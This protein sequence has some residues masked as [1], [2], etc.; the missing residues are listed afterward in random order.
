MI[1]P[2]TTTAAPSRRTSRIVALDIA[3]GI[4]ILGTLGTNIWIFSHPAG[5]LGYLSEPT[6]PVEGWQP[7]AQRFL[8]AL[9]NGKFLGLL[10]LMFGIGLAIQQQSAVRRGRRWPGSYPW[11]TALLFL[12]GVLHYF[13]VV[14]FDVLMGYAVTGLIVAWIIA[15]TPAA[16]RRWIMITAGVHVVI[17]LALTAL[18]IGSG[19]AQRYNGPNPYADGSWFDLVRLRW[20][21]L[22]LFRLEPV[23]ILLMGIALFTLGARLLSAGLFEGRG[24]PLRQRLIMVG[25]GALALDLILAMTAPDTVLISR[26]V[27]APIVALGLLSAIAAFWLDRSPG[28]IGRRL[29]EV[30]RIAL[31]CY[32]LQNLLAAILFQGWGFGLSQAP[33]QWRTA[34]TVSAYAG[35]CAVMVTAAH[36][37]LRRF[38][39]GPVEWAWARGYALLAREPG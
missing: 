5:F 31:T 9:A 22:G 7:R 11:R 15:G 1:A 12:D 17:I 35:L 33:K 21:F 16:Q 36:L 14:E 23:L 29:G 38:R 19:P 2:A 4:A 32:I 24:A 3:R 18:L 39:R 25:A 30:G 8:M 37:W 34:I 10:T 13:L 28:V 20:Q 26:Y 27:L 6:S